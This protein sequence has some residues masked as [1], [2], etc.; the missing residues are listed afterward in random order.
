MM[1]TIENSPAF[2]FLPLKAQRSREGVPRRSGATINIPRSSTY[3]NE[4][5]KTDTLAYVPSV[6]VFKDNLENDDDHVALTTNDAADKLSGDSRRL[7]TLLGASKVGSLLTM[8]NAPHSCTSDK[9]T[10]EAPSCF[11]AACV[12]AFFPVIFIIETTIMTEN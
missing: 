12:E 9:L 7:Q 5:K 3:K 10:P 8:M 1:R 6:Y 2:T 4:R 11:Y